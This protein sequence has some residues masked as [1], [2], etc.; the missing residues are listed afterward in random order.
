MT[1]LHSAKK[2][3]ATKAFDASKTISAEHIEQLKAIIRLSPSSVNIQA[4]HFMVAT[5]DRAKEKIAAACPGAMAYNAKKIKEAPLVIVFCAH[6]SVGEQTVAR[7]VEQEA[8]DNR[9][10]DEQAQSDRLALLTNHIN[11]LNKNPITARAWVD[12][13]TYI[14]LGSVLLAAAD[15]G[16]DSVPIEGYDNSILD[17][18]LGLTEKGLHSTVI[19]AFGYRSSEDFNATLTKSRLPN[20]EL[21]ETI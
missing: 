14:A 20:D 9:Y 8:Q 12:K 4:W 18:A 10:A 5:T 19:A 7:I 21:F 11:R 13:Q 3:Y 2:R 1:I 6:D 15:M 17:K 16:I